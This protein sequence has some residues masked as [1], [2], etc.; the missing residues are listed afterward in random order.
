[1]DAEGPPTAT[2]SDVHHYVLRVTGTSATFSWNSKLQTNGTHT[3][4]VSCTDANNNFGG[5]S[6]Q[7]TIAN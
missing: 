2:S 3:L 1:V 5:T 6:E 7:V 4:W